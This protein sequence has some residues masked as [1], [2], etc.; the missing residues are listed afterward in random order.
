M[1]EDR[2]RKLARILAETGKLNSEDA[3]AILLREDSKGEFH[4]EI[5]LSGNLANLTRAMDEAGIPY[6]IK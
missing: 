4:L 1:E 3:K 2:L 5:G 6:T